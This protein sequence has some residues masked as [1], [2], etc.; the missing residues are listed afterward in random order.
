MIQRW[1]QPVANSP[2]FQG[3][4]LVIIGFASLLVGLETFEEVIEPHDELFGALDKLLLAVFTVEVLIRLGAYGGRPWRFFTDPW[5]VFDFV[6]VVIFYIPFVGTEASLLRLA[7]VIRML[8]LVRA[9][10]EL[11]LLIGALLHSL[12]SISYIGLLMLML[13]YVYA[14]LGSFVLGQSDPER[15]GNVALAMQT[16]LQVVTF[17]DWMLVMRAQSNQAFAV[18]YFVSFILVGTM[19]ILNLFIGV[20]ME[21]FTSARQERMDDLAAA[22]AAE[23]VVQEEIEVDLTQ[24]NRQ[25][26]EVRADVAKLV[27]L[28]ERERAN[29]A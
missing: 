4:I 29:I 27:A 9:V 19:I 12:P 18:P 8:R 7:R 28:A 26:A 1:C 5:N 25:L 20:I 10:P 6:T 11:R 14:V 21:G 15:F 22:V 13:I 3:F 23:E 24:I 16:M 17:D 2:R